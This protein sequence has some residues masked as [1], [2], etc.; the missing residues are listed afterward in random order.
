MMERMRRGYI[1][2][3]P[4]WKSSKGL[5]VMTDKKIDRKWDIFTKPHLSI[6]SV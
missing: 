6:I 1:N 4:L 3:P 5:N 2:D